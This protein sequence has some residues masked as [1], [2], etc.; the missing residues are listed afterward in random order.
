[1][2]RLVERCVRSG[3]HAGGGLGLRDGVKRLGALQRVF[4]AV[5]EPQRLVECRL[6]LLVIRG[7]CLRRRDL[8]QHC[9]AHKQPI[10]D[11]RGKLRGHVDLPGLRPGL[12]DRGNECLAPVRPVLQVAQI[13]RFLQEASA[14]GRLE[15][16]LP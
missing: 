4:P 13:H 12:G 6:G 1:M 15:T 9:G 8:P 7:T 2:Q 5:G 14:I 16:I 11:L 10:R 3:L